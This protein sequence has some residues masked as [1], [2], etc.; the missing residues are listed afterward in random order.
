MGQPGPRA[1]RLLHEGNHGFRPD[2][3]P[4]LRLVFA[5]GNGR[6]EGV[7]VIQGNRAYRGRRT[8]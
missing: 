8:P 4:G 5:L 1:K 7:T 2:G 6:A 3:E